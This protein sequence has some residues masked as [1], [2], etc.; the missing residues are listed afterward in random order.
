MEQRNNDAAIVAYC[1]RLDCQTANSYP[2]LICGT[3]LLR[4]SFSVSPD[5]KC[6]G[7]HDRRSGPQCIIT[8]DEKD[9]PRR[10]KI[11]RSLASVKARSRHVRLATSSSQQRCVA[12]VCCSAMLLRVCLR[13]FRRW[14]CAWSPSVATLNAL[15]P[16]LRRCAIAMSTPR[17][18]PGQNAYLCA[19]G[20]ADIVASDLALY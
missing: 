19:S 5:T 11:R 9:R 4:S 16:I 15:M 6:S 12:D 8:D 14:R 2:R 1:V 10:M 13:L 20:S 18:S 3:Q 7:S 17:P